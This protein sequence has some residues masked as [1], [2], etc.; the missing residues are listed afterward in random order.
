VF[1]RYWRFPGARHVRTWSAV[2]VHCAISI[3]G[4]ACAVADSAISA[5]PVMKIVFIVLPVY[6][7]D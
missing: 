2:A 7:F 6:Q 1:R 4:A 3:L 5:H